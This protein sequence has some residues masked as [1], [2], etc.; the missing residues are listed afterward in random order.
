MTIEIEQVKS[1]RQLG[2]MLT[3]IHQ[4]QRLSRLVQDFIELGELHF[5]L[6]VGRISV[7]HCGRLAN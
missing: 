6:V 3:L 2:A 7:H 4:I 5:G 1:G